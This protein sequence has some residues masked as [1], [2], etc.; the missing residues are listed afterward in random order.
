MSEPKSVDKHRMVLKLIGA[1]T[2]ASAVFLLDLWAS[3]A[4]G[5]MTGAR[6]LWPADVTLLG[7]AWPRELA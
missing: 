5:T 2:V 3:P 7:L 6:R 1:P 4:S